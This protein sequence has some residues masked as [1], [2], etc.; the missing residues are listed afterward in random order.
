MG[1]QK[2]KTFEVRD[3]FVDYDFE[4]V[5]FRWDHANQL[6]YRKFYGKL[7]DPDP[8]A[9]HSKLFNDSL[10]FGD[11]ISSEQYLEGK[12]RRL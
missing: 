12:V 2:G 11:E 9:H 10:L 3:V 1:I 8:I 6:I 5:M 7:E 4:E